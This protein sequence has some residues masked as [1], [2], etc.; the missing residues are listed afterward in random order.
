MQNIFITIE[1]HLAEVII[2]L[3]V[4]CLL[5]LV[6]IIMLFV[7]NRA[8][9]KRV[10]RFM[11][12]KSEKHNIEAMLLEHM[13]TVSH[14]DDKYNSVM[15]SID[16]INTRLSFCIQKVSLVRYNPF[17]NVGSDLSFAL[18]LLDEHNN[19]VVINTIFGRDATYTYAKPIL[20]TESN[21]T[22]SQEEK[23]AV[24]LAANKK[25]E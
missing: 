6:L 20:A 2:G 12:S 13:E 5:F 3:G 16:D 1:G 4:L 19:G 7:S 21:R 8:L 24:R 25:A 22:L 15:A 18:A 17:E 11:G 9:K 23:E 14:V 10:D